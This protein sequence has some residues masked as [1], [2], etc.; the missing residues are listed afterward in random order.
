MFVTLVVF[1]TWSI[2]VFKDFS[3]KTQTMEM[4]VED[5]FYP[6]HVTICKNGWFNYEND[7]NFMKWL[8]SKYPCGSNFRN[9]KKAVQ[10][11]LQG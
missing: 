7:D 6:P 10:S 9:Y 8:V 3:D 1:F 11:C 2:R 5:E 4:D